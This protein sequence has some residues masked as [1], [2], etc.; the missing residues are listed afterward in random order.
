MNLGYRG[1]NPYNTPRP[2]AELILLDALREWARK[3]GLAS[4]NT[5]AIRG[6]DT[7]RPIGPF[8]FDLAGPSWFAP[9]QRPGGKPGFLVADVFDDG[10]LTEY[11][12]RFFLR[13]VTM[14]RSL[15]NGIQHYAD[16]CRRKIHRRGVDGKA[17]RRD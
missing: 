14:L 2:T 1:G 12:I 16:P 11:Q 13:K 3:L 17:R 10:T 8:M 4:Y 6:E 7:L 9:V 15:Q 5:I